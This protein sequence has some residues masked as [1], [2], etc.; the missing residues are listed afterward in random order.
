MK[1]Y[2]L[3]SN[4]IIA[5][6]EGEKS[7]LGLIQI[8]EDA[9]NEKVK[10]FFC[11]INW[12]EVYYIAL[13]EGGKERAEKYRQIIDQYPIEVINVDKDLTLKAAYYKA[14][15]KMSYSDAFA[16]AL[17]DKLNATLIT[18][19]PEF[20]QLKNQIKILFLK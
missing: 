19:D 10:L 8:L 13:R 18:G 20:N 9:I 15:N 12:G 3:D 14:F 17:T 2:V 11:L 7:G 1:K 4:S 6:L 16:A 5:Y